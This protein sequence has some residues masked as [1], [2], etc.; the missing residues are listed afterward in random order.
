MQ[1][2][3]MTKQIVIGLRWQMTNESAHVHMPWKGLML[4]I[5]LATLAANTACSVAAHDQLAWTESKAHSDGL[6][7]RS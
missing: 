4:L 3:H 2:Y 5:I 7:Q 1:L 6:H